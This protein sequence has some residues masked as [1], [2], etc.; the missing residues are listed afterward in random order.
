MGRFAAVC[1]I[2]PLSIKITNPPPSTSYSSS[3]FS[4]SSFSFPAR[5]II[6]IIPHRNTQWLLSVWKKTRR[7]VSYKTVLQ[8]RK[9]QSLEEEA[10]QKIPS[11]AF[12]QTKKYIQRSNNP[13]QLLSIHRKERKISLLQGF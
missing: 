13:T 1:T 5:D 9:G 12:K 8:K 6:I 4:S 3:A 11:T 7:I 2:R 10:S